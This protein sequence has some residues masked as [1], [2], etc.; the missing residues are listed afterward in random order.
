MA[1]KKIEELFA[2]RPDEVKKELQ[3]Q[4]KKDI[5]KG[6]KKLKMLKTSAK[7]E[8]TWTRLKKE[9][10]RVGQVT[11]KTLH[12]NEQISSAEDKISESEKSLFKIK[13]LTKG[14]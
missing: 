4:I 2:H 5:S 13:A 6:E 14:Y 8:R 3:E 7:Q 1:D 11:A 9:L 10:M 12:F